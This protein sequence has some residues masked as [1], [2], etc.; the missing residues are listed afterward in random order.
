MA[1]EKEALVN[2]FIAELREFGLLLPALY[3]LMR[4]VYTPLYKA[5]LLTQTIPAPLKVAGM[6]A[7]IVS[8]T[9]LI[10]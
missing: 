1:G 4:V 6:Q 3:L 10:L 5:G 2:S 7:G 9:L 8:A